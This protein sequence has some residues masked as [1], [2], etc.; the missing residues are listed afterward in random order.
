MTNA[1]INFFLSFII[2]IKGEFEPND[3]E[4]RWIGMVEIQNYPL[5]SIQLP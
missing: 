1:I 3:A 4:F 2:F 5:G